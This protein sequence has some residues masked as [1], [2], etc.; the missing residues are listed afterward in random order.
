[1]RLKIEL[2]TGERFHVLEPVKRSLHIASRWFSGAAEISTYRL[3]ELLGTKLRALYQRKKCRDLFDLWHAS[4]LANPDPAVIAR[5]F[6]E[7]LKRSSLTVSR[8]EFEENLIRKMRDRISLSDVV[9][10]LAPGVPWDPEAAAT[11]LLQRI[12]PSLPGK[13]WKSGG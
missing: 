8:A 1:M 9:P 11:Y 4:N 3:E 13:P 12:L 5:C 2:N 7:Y 10:L 6:T